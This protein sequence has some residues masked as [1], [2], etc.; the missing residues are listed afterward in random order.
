MQVTLRIV[1]LFFNKKVQI[2]ATVKT[3]K[4]VMDAYRKNGKDKTSKVGG[5][6]YTTETHDDTIKK[7]SFNFDGKYDFEGDSPANG[8]G[9]TLGGQHL[10][11]RVY[12]LSERKLGKN[13]QLAWQYYVLDKSGNNKS[14]TKQAEEF[15]PFGKKTHTYNIENGDTIIWRLVA[16]NCP[17]REH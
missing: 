12:S 15:T 2:D 1:G 5:L 3:V 9:K 13:S 6:T 10:P 8:N 16:I 7:I 14:K 11:K 17:K 4:D